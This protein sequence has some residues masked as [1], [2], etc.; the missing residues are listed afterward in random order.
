MGELP[1][2]WINKGVSVADLELLLDEI[3]QWGSCSWG[4]VTLSRSSA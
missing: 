4:S 3:K 2:P 1:G